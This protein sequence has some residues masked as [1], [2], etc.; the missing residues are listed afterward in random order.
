MDDMAAGINAYLSKR[1]IDTLKP[2]LIIRMSGT[3]EQEGRDMLKK[4]GISS[5]DNIYD[6]V[7]TAVKLAGS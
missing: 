1:P 3:L 7:Q 6:A 4:R 2:I 5:Y